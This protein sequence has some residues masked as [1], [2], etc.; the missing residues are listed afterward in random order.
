MLHR[1]RGLALA[2]GVKCKFIKGPHRLSFSL[3]E[4]LFKNICSANLWVVNLKRHYIWRIWGRRE[5]GHVLVPLPVPL[6]T[7][8]PS[9]GP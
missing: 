7:Y 5:S 9:T 4:H 6:A 2:S 3:L 1:S 8:C